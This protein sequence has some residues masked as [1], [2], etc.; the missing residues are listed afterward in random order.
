MRPLW[1]L[2]LLAILPATACGF[3]PPDD[4]ACTHDEFSLRV[5]ATPVQRVDLLVWVDDSPSMAEE[6]A[7]LAEQL[8][9]LIREM[10]EPGDRDGD[11]RPDHPPIQD[12][13]VGIVEPGAPTPG[14]LP[15]CLGP[16][17]LGSGCLVGG[18][19]NP[20]AGCEATYP[21]FFPWNAFDDDGT[22][23][24]RIA[25]GVGCLGPMGTAGCPASQPFASVVRALTVDAE[26]SGCNEGFLRDDAM[27][28][29]LWISDGDDGSASAAHP[30]LF[31]PGTALGEP[32]TRAA[33]HP[34]LLEPVDTFLDAIRRLK[35]A[36]D[37]NKLVLGMIVGVPLDAPVCSGSGD[38]LEGC[39]GVPTMQVATDPTDPT[40]LI[41]SCLSAGA[42]AT[43][44]RRF[45]QLAQAFG[46]NAEVVSICRSDWRDALGG[47]LDRLCQRLPDVCLPREIPL[48]EGE[49]IPDC[50]VVETLFDDRPCAEDP[51][52]PSSWCPPAEEGDALAPPPCVDP[53]TGA[54]C[55]PFKRDLGVMT[56]SDGVARRKCLMRP[57]ART[58]DATSGSCG[59][60]ENA[61][62]VYFPQGAEEWTCPRLMFTEEDYWGGGLEPGSRGDLRCGWTACE[63]EDTAGD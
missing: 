46:T 35:S 52:C 27:L 7:A 9:V 47:V 60:P 24:E 39:L 50:A 57:A 55:R 25:A 54:E 8:P 43:P 17:G 3:E 37:Q 58:W 36:E 10:L 4:P 30:E 21:P 38:V 1:P 6:Q 51:T 42:M 18:P 63:D 41:P 26:A 53:T 15:G 40:Q 48:D 61:G 22:D 62:W 12:L 16:D 2:V 11:T 31:D 20:G 32:E 5:E 19:R 33:L 23:A 49:C 28:Y 45:V 44:P 14:G 59:V 56:E 13:N 34:E 29:I